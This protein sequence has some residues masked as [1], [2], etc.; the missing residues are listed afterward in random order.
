MKPSLSMF[1]GALVMATALTSVLAIVPAS[2][3]A[4]AYPTR[5]V[6]IIVTFAPGGTVDVFARIAAEKLSQRMGQQ[7]YVENVAGASGNIATGQ[8]ARATPDGHTLLAA[9][10]TH[11]VNPSLFASVPYDPVKDFEPISLA[12]SAT[13]VI[14]VHPSVPAISLKELVDVIRA[15]PGKYN[16]AHGGAGTPAHLLG[17]QFRLTQKLDIVPVPF[18]GAGPAVASVL[19]G[20]TPIGFATVASALSQ[21]EGDKLRALAVTS[22]ARASQLKAVP[23]TAEA[24]YPDIVGDIWVGLMAPAGTPKPIVEQLHKATVAVIFEPDTRERLAKVGFETVGTTPDQ[25]RQQIVSELESWRK[26]IE[27]AKVKQQ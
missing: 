24:G 15:N 16:F 1:A 18:N 27:A 8:A 19:G 3:Q 17:E 10:S 14:A 21:I 4:Q 7:F 9:F 2:A 6:R 23:T 5:P 12:V 20:H 26:L 25:F 22:K 13:H 11:V